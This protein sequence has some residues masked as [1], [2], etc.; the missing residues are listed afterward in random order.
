MHG[1]LTDPMEYDTGTVPVFLDR[2]LRLVF[3]GYCFGSCGKRSAGDGEQVT[4]Q[5]DRSRVI[6]G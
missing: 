3:S 6:R 2:A 1:I 5:P 4:S